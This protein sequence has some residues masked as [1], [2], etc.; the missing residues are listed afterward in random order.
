MSL[1]YHTLPPWF[2]V[3]FPP[4]W[5]QGW[6]M[7]SVKQKDDMLLLQLSSDSEPFR[8]G[9]STQAVGS[10][11]LDYC[12][13]QLPLRSSSGFL[14]KHFPCLCSLMLTPRKEPVLLSKTFCAQQVALY[15][16][17]SKTSLKPTRWQ[18]VGL[19]R[20]SL[21]LFCYCTMRN[22]AH[23]WVPTKQVAFVKFSSVVQNTGYY[24]KQY[25][26]V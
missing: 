6:S 17:K 26:K 11:L 22:N 8:A 3:K 20:L 4:T 14:V 7:W 1:L 10:P 2:A 19:P 16:F 5:F 23:G 24:K 18:V 21:Q 15:P 13:L 9:C 12:T 25:L